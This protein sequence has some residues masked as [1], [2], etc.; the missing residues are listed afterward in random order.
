MKKILR[1]NKK[2]L[3]ANIALLLSAC[4]GSDHTVS[5][6]GYAADGYLK[7]ANVCLDTDKDGSCTGESTITTTG[8]DGQFTLDATQEE[9]D[10][11]SILVEAI[12]GTT[13][14]LDNPDSPVAK[15]FTLNSPPG[16]R[17]EEGGVV[18]N[19]LTTL[20]DIYTALPPG[21]ANFLA[22]GLKNGNRDIV[23][24]SG[25]IDLKTL[26]KLKTDAFGRACSPKTY[27]DF[28]KCL[29]DDYTKTAKIANADPAVLA[30]AK[31]IQLTAQ[32]LTK[33]FQTTKEQT[34]NDP[35][36][37][38]KE[39]KEA[40]AKST[41]EKAGNVAED[42]INEIEKNNG[43][44]TKVDTQKIADKN[45]VVPR[46]G[47][48]ALI[49]AD[50]L[51]TTAATVTDLT[52]NTP[53]Y[54]LTLNAVVIAEETFTDPGNITDVKR[55][56]LSGKPLAA[57]LQAHAE[58]NSR[59][60]QDIF[61]Q[62]VVFAEG[63]AAYQVTTT[64]AETSATSQTVYVTQAV[65]DQVIAAVNQSALVNS[66]FAAK[67]DYATGVG[68][69]SVTSADVNGD[70]HIDLAVANSDSDSVSV[71][72]GDGTGSFAAKVDYATGSGS[73]SVT[74]ADVNGDG[75]V[76]LAVANMKA[77]T[78]S[79][80]LGDGTGSFAAK[81]DYTT[82]SGPTSVTSADV[83][84]DGFVDLAVAN[85]FSDTVSVLL[86][87]GTGSFAAKVDYATGSGPNA[88]ISTDVNGDGHVDLAVANG[89]PH[90]VSVL[91]GDGTG[92]FAA[93]VDYATGSTPHSVISTDVN[94][95]GHVDLAVANIFSDTVSV[96]LGDGTGSFA[97]KV[98]Y[99]TGSLPTSVTSA[100][101]NG[102]G[103]VDLAV[104]NIFSGTVSVLLGDGTGSFAAKVD[105]ATGSGSGPTSVT[106]ADV[107]G[108]GFVDLAVASREADTVSVLLN[109]PQ[110]ASSEPVQCNY[111]TTES[112]DDSGT[113]GGTTTPEPTDPDS[114]ADGVPDATDAF[115]NDPNETVD[116]DGDG[117]GDNA[118]AFPND[119]T[120][121]ADADSD[122]VGDNADAFPNDAT[123]TA[124]SDSDGVGDNADAFPNDATETADS[125]SDGV[126]DNADAFP[127]D[128]TET[129][130]ADSDGVGDNADAFPYDETETMDTDGDGVGD[131]IDPDPNDPNIPGGPGGPECDPITDPTCQM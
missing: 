48:N 37:N 60:W 34:E 39:G 86:G 120:E 75:H 62:C 46:E 80:L 74:S 66:N 33:V 90:T 6:S 72:L 64:D 49:S 81:V 96:L 28:R 56:D 73:I 45:Q 97:A 59:N 115:P 15:A 123:E 71:L 10:K 104:A 95:D 25:P 121:A 109:Q 67:V 99:A 51:P 125:D 58:S 128:A 1:T 63:S 43:D 23:K 52:D 57:T 114:D 106:S 85:I 117:V 88:V 54:A 38:T 3:I 24:T 101:V 84:G 35:A 127:N 26:E 65:R 118:D 92:S 20:L 105:Y 27:E 122:G 113:D 111:P 32:A 69:R 124:D 44:T 5:Q 4:G 13:I 70:G 110:S 7:F 112:A 14:D 30:S 79:V 130:D 50:Q 17:D 29:T 55:F 91:L 53:L 31:R 9:F 19:P 87:D 2:F 61:A 82:G 129:A 126:G 89:S 77:D 94:G 131:N 107:N 116:S 108:D 103:H 93:K 36:A 40:I 18:V 16:L 78:V 100:D 11:Y 21:R 42:V 22:E 76:D 8:D 98:D 102:D 47:T 119:A 12:A 41:V 83:N 68:P